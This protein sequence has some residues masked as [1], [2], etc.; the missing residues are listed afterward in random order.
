MFSLPL[1]EAEMRMHPR[2]H[3]EDKVPVSTRSAPDVPKSV[4]C[5]EVSWQGPAHS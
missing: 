3:S 5:T 4:P 1:L 2:S